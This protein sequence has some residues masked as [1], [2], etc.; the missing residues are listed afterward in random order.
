M[1]NTT[2]RSRVST[3]LGALQE[4]ATLAVDAKAKELKAAGAPVIGY[5]AGEPNFPTPDHIVDAAAE[6][7]RDPKNHKYTP[8]IGLLDL[9]KA[10]A[11]RVKA[12]SGLDVD[13]KNII[14]TNG[15]KQAVFQAFASIVSEGDDVILPAPYWTTYPEVIRLAG[16]TPVEVFAG[17]EQEYKVTVAQ[18]DAALT[19]KTKALLL[20]SPSNPTGAVYSAEEIRAIGQW[21][22]DNGIW[23]ITDE[24]Y[25]R[26]IY[27][28]EMAYL[29][30][31]MPELADQ[32]IVVSGVAKTYA[33]TGWRVGWMY[34]PADVMKQAAN[35]QSHATSNVNNVAQVAALAAL[36]G[37]QSIVD[38]MKAAFDRR[39]LKLVEML[40]EIEGFEVPEPTGA[41]YVFPKVEK[42]L[43]KEIKGRVAATSAE[44]ASI[45]LE[46]AEV[47]VVPGEAF[48]APGYLRFSYALADDDLEAGA[49]R[50]QELFA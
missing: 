26:L 43:G 14:V 24:I 7:C 1:A 38:E 39:R 33:M 12:D 21:A 32:T 4:S 15:G 50:L 42:L 30:G 27:S 35:F 40:R 17:V 48:G 18:L 44:L 31:E 46:E 8:A 11:A 28:G 9:R 6:A 37:D 5:G 3:R 34:G 23:I 10:I 49:R 47:A 45:I 22:L 25:E 19:D 20:C 36:T 13:P 41:F 16:G 29:L 2:P